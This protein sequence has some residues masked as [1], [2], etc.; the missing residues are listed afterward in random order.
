MNQSSGSSVQ[1]ETFPPKN[2]SLYTKYTKRSLLYFTERFIFRPL[3]LTL[4]FRVY[5]YTADMTLF[6]YVLGSPVSISI[7]VDIGDPTKV[8]N[9]DIPI[10]NLTFGHIK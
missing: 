1:T 7:P 9:V 8:D 3:F 10:N 2:I 5:R 6:C 4:D